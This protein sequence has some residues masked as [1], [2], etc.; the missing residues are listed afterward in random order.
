MSGPLF[1]I[2]YALL[3]LA[4]NVWLRRRLRG[5]EAMQ[6][7]RFLEF[8]QDPYQVA[9]LRA[10]AAE[11]VRLVIFSLVD[12]GLLEEDGGRVRLARQNAAEYVRRP[13]E[14]A[15]L[16]RCGDW[17][18]PQV[19]L[20]DPAVARA[21]QGVHCGLAKAALV[22]DAAVYAA[23][24]K[25]FLAAS[26]VLLGVAAARIAWALAHG[27]HN[28]GFLL[29]FAT[30]GGIAL[31]V[32]WRR[33]RTG[34]GDAALERLARLFAGL[35]LRASQLQPGGQS[36]EAALAAAL[37]GFE[38]LP[39]AGFPWLRRLYPPSSGSGGDGGGSS[40]DSSCDSGGGASDCG[41]GCGGCGGD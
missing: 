5:H 38:I 15:V 33:R 27:R 30:I 6:P 8:A 35:K 18:T 1:L 25:P 23:R 3:A 29:L 16:A 11:A 28:I 4:T 7:A 22:A 9:Y 34:L 21:C 40:S 31:I 41:G 13:V 36:H 12:R 20:R 39:A 32:A 14:H 26:A 10:G 17:Q 24:F 2:V 19:I 37:F